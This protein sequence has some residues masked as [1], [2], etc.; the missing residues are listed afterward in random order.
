M[1]S[2]PLSV[3]CW[4]ALDEEMGWPSPPRNGLNALIR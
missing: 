2:I 1:N 3:P 4:C